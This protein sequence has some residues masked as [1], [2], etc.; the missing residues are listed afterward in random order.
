[1]IAHYACRFAITVQTGELPGA[2]TTAN[3]FLRVQLEGEELQEVELSRDADDF[4]RGKRQ[5]FEVQLRG[6][7]SIVSAWLGHDDFGV[8]QCKQFE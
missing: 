8:L 4:R 7:G 1:L 5:T 3:V 2:S 6:K